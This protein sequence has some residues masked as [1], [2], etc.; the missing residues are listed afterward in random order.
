MRYQEMKNSFKE[1]NIDIESIIRL[2]RVRSNKFPNCREGADLE[3]L[4]DHFYKIHG[5]FPYSRNSFNLIGEEINHEA[6]I[7]ALGCSVTAAAGIPHQLTWPNFLR[8]I[9]NTDVN[10]IASPG[11]DI[12]EILRI[13]NVYLVSDNF[14]TPDAVYI[15]APDILR[16]NLRSIGMNQSIHLEYNDDLGFLTRKK[17]ATINDRH[18]KKF[19]PSVSYTLM[20][21]LSSLE[22]CVTLCKTFGIDVVVSS[23]EMYTQKIFQELGYID[24]ID[25]TG[26][27]SSESR[28]WEMVTPCVK[29]DFINVPDHLKPFWNSAIDGPPPH[30]GLHHHIHYIEDLLQ[31]DINY[32]IINELD[33]DKAWLQ[34]I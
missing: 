10:V 18:I 29:H 4:S 21:R 28:M 31:K 6:R 24:K 23:W 8:K 3:A 17:I 1:R 5:N 9:Y 16:T 12:M 15:L 32:D 25:C 27:F 20:D 30:P 19:T 13:L 7:L 11:L 2:A 33:F 14:C 26:C 34:Y 22:M